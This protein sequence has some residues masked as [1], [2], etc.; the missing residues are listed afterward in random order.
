[1]AQ[2]TLIY[3]LA[4]I[5]AIA[6]KWTRKIAVTR[7]SKFV[8]YGVTSFPMIAHFIM[9]YDNMLPKSVSIKLI[10]LSKRQNANGN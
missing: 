2:P 5:P 10:F 4:S 9:K 1:M 8:F 6:E 3:S 7:S